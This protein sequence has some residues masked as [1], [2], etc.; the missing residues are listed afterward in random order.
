MFKFK[1]IRVKDEASILT[2]RTK[3]EK[4]IYGIAFVVFAIYSI[5][6]VS[7]ILRNSRHKYCFDIPD[8]S[9]RLSIVISCL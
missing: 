9:Q 8:T 6:L 7:S 5:G 4:V 2:K 1:N 3:G